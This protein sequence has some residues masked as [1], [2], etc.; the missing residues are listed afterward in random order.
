M[1]MGYEIYRSLVL[2][3]KAEDGSNGYHKYL[4]SPG[5]DLVVVD[6][7]HRISNPNVRTIRLSLTSFSPTYQK[8]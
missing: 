8:L 5:P 3:E 7:A 6:E 1:I 2:S 4:L